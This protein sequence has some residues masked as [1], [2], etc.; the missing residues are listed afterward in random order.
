M[1][2][3]FLKK[4]KNINKKLGSFKYKKGVLGRILLCQVEKTAEG[5]KT[6]HTTNNC[7]CCIVMHPT[8]RSLFEKKRGCV[9]PNQEPF[10]A[11]RQQAHAMTKPLPKVSQNEVKTIGTTIYKTFETTCKHRL[12][13]SFSEVLTHSRGWNETHLLKE[14]KKIEIK[15]ENLKKALK[16]PASFI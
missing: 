14:R 9:P 7:K 6:L 11:I 16:I 2:G 5:R 1:L 3:P 13:K 10:T 8:E 15:K 12:G 4:Y